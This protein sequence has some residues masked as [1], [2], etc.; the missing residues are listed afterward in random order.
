[1]ICKTE[2]RMNDPLT[3][4]ERSQRMALV[5]GKDTKPEMRVRRLVHSLGYRYRL[6]ARELPGQPDLVLRPRRKLIFVHGCFWH[7][8]NCSMGSRMPK[9][10]VDF[11]RQKLEGN[12]R[13]DAEIQRQL[14]DDGWSVMVIWEC[15]TARTNLE[16][17]ATEIVA[18]IEHER[19]SSVP[20]GTD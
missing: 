12:K 6:H 19:E 3:Q 13:R 2:L 18:F 17:L 14:N 8:H 20:C 16:R 5:R 7:Q 9:T 1:M 10:R 11:W 4:A 15:Q